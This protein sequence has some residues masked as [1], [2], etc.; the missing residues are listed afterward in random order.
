MITRYAFYIS[1]NEKLF[2]DSVCFLPVFPNGPSSPFSPLRVERGF[3]CSLTLFQIQFQ[4]DS[5]RKRPLSP[6]DVPTLRPLN[7]TQLETIRSLL[8][9]R[10]VTL[11]S[12]RE[13]VRGT[14]EVGRLK[15]TKIAACLVQRKVNEEK[16]PFATPPFFKSG[17]EATLDCCQCCRRRWWKMFWSQT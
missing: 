11:S 16:T 8:C 9:G 3:F 1:M 12:T 5:K 6:R 14:S 2:S 10:R 4:H 17:F 13:P 15:R 7:V